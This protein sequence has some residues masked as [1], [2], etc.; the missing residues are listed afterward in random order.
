MAIFLKVTD[1]TA[2]YQSFYGIVIEEKLE[3]ERNKQGDKNSWNEQTKFE[4]IVSD[5]EIKIQ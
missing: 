5:C 4:Q 1:F 3:K 2:Y